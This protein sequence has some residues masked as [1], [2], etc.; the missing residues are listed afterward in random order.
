M[1]LEGEKFENCRER[2]GSEIKN[3]NSSLYGKL[4][5]LDRSRTV[6]H[7]LKFKTRVLAIE[8]ANEELSMINQKVFSTKKLDGLR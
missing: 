6:E 4:I 2:L 8:H 3:R 7:L 5:N 1:S